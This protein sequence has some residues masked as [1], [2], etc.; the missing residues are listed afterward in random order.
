MDHSL[1][2]RTFAISGA[3]ALAMFGLVSKTGLAAP[4]V[5]SGGGISGGGTVLADGSPGEFSVFGSR[6]LTDESDSPLFIGQLSYND[7]VAKMTVQSLEIVA[8]GPVEGQENTMR[9]MSG[10]ASVNGAGKHPFNLIL[11]DGGPIGSGLD[12]FTLT[13]G[14]DGATEVTDPMLQ[15]DSAVQAGDLALVDF[16]FGSSVASP[17]PAG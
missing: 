8:Y 4:V 12:H 16:D 15:V 5:Q 9:Q 13:V 2:R 10:F 11:T 17:T 7:V 6:F 1:T 14:A 3:P